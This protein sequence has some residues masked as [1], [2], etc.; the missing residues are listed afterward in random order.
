MPFARSRWERAIQ[1]RQMGPT[2]AHAPIFQTEEAKTSPG[3]GNGLQSCD[4]LTARKR[5]KS[6]SSLLC[7]IS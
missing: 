5:R 7:Q 6:D 3:A 2:Q 4:I 1:E